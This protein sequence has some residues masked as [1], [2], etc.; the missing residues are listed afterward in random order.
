MAD[1]EL[2]E[3]R[4]IERS[5][6]RKPALPEVPDDRSPL[7]AMGAGGP[8]PNFL[9]EAAQHEQMLQLQRVHGNSYV[10][11]VVAEQTAAE[12]DQSTTP[13]AAGPAAQAG[14]PPPD[15][16]AEISQE[17]TRV[18]AP[19][20]ADVHEQP[21]AQ[22][23]EESGR[24]ALDSL[25]S[26]A[27][28]AGPASPP[29]AA[30]PPAAGA[31]VADAAS[32]GP[33]DLGLAAPADAST[34]VAQQSAA[35]L[36]TT[37][38][39]AAQLASAPVAFAPATEQGDRS[40]VQNAAVA[41]GMLSDFLA[42]VADRAQQISLLASPVADTIQTAAAGATQTV[43][44]HADE[45]CQAIAAHLEE[46]RGQAIAGAQ[47]ARDTVVQQ[48]T[49]TTAALTQATSNARQQLESE[50]SAAL[51][52]IE[53]RESAQLQ[54]I[55]ARYAAGD[56]RFREAGRVVGDEAVQRGK[57]MADQY[58][59]GLVDEDDSFL[60]GPLTYNRG[61]ARADT[62]TQMG[63]GYQKGLQDEA[64]KQ[65]DQAQQGK[66][67]DVETARTTARQA[68]EAL[69]SQY[70]AMLKT[71][72]DAEASALAQAEQAR[73]GL[74]DG[75]DQALQ[76]AVQAL[77]QH[78]A[79]LQQG[80][81]EAAQAQSA[82]IEQQADQLIGAIHDQ[83]A[84]AAAGVLDSGSTMAAQLHGQAAP[85][86]DIFGAALAEATVQLDAGLAQIQGQ[87]ADG[88]TAGEQQITQAA[89]AVGGGLDAST[90]SGLDG[91]SQTATEISTTL[92]SIG[93]SASET[94]SN[95]Q[96]SHN[97]VLATSCT[98]A[99]GGFSQAVDGVQQ[100][101]EQMSAGLERG[102]AENAAALEQG[103]RGALPKM[104]DEIRI[105]A[106]ENASHVPPRWKS[107]V[108]WLLIIAVIVVVALVVGPFV[109]GAVGAALG[110]GAV[111]T[112]II[113]GAIVGA[114][115]SATIQVINNW[116]ENKPLGEGVM[117]AAVIGAIGGAVGGGFGAWVG[118]LG[119]QGVSIA[120]SAFKQFAL[121]TVA[122]IV[123]ENTI[124]IA[125]GN[126]SWSSFGMSVLSAVAVGGAMHAA[127]GLE[128]ISGLQESAMASGEGVGGSIRTAMGGTVSINYRPTQ[129][130]E[131]VAP[132]DSAPVSNAAQT[133][134]LDE[135]PGGRGS[136]AND[137]A[138]PPDNGPGGGTSQ[139]VPSKETDLP[140]GPAAND[141]AEPEALAATGTDDALPLTQ[142]DQRK[143]QVLED[144]R[145]PDDAPRAMSNNNRTGDDASVSGASTPR[146]DEPSTS[147][148]SGTSSTPRTDE[149]STSGSGTS[150]SPQK[151]DDPTTSP[152]SPTAPTQEGDIS[153]ILE[154]LPEDEQNRLL[155]RVVRGDAKG[156]AFGTP[157]NERMPTVE[158]FNPRIEE[159]RA[160]DLGGT[161][162]DTRHGISPDQAG[163]VGQLSNDDLI[164]FRIEDPISGTGG[165]GA[166]S[167]TGGHHRI[168]EIVSR[169]ASGRL[170]P[171]TIIK[172]LV[173]D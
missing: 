142:P 38:S 163:S 109:I 93:G 76:G 74:C 83:I 97:G 152:V 32:A 75:I 172:V 20:S 98:A 158:E 27:A 108:K 79:A 123:T 9:D 33:V 122:N 43:A 31:P 167:V 36:D 23:L 139:A 166:L 5:D 71:L 39:S 106:E 133:A 132:D 68:R 85:A 120:S 165:Q 16:Q 86:P 15:P 56:Q 102:F 13:G 21:P 135:I 157:R 47:A 154:S 153:K 73:A 160:G 138:L 30:A 22:M 117:R 29:P 66:A 140:R 87:I 162:V 52:S 55:D 60:D 6:A 94:F 111:M 169:V 19:T 147:G 125:T 144:G 171:D 99:S 103:L 129:P 78:E 41:S 35:Q 159:I 137:N 150:S 151:V 80:A 114:A 107:V 28:Q 119:Q 168:A 65:A 101:Y 37:R 81:R 112:G 34:S 59:A 42:T 134:T 51:Q 64:N 143:F 149:P 118:Q 46:L 136:A 26:V 53:A 82:D 96:Q 25:S 155:A 54:V 173:H 7:G 126:F 14:P 170:P 58:M 100:A 67:H 50:Y 48:F 124:N 17:P 63:E 12:S 156:R 3:T 145:G 61:K 45:Q 49:T 62:A 10:Q 95:I 161:V 115:T 84:Q 116:A 91:A 90:Q 113:A 24:S 40:E 146:T 77:A 148:T 18:E 105:K 88:L 110:T 70:T 8:I 89:A 44:G 57:Q 11:R 164:R 4:R 128:S 72:A 131:K 141:N 1:V 69:T 130:A 121:N 127:S 92:Q 104:E 2:L